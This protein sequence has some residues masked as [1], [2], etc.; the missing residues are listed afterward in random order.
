MNAFVHRLGAMAM[1]VLAATAITSPARAQDTQRLVEEVVAHVNADI[2]TRSQYYEA[3]ADAERD[4]KENFKEPEATQKFLEFRPKILD[5]MI[6]NMLLVQKGQDLQIDVEAQINAQLKRQADEQRKSITEFEEMMRSAGIDPNE[7]RARLRE[8]MMRDAVLQQEVYGGIWRNLTEKQK[9][10]FY[11]AHKDKFLEPG[12]LKISEL[13]LSVEGRSFTEIEAKA[14]EIIAAAR[15]GQK[16]ADLVKKFGDPGRPSFA[17]N[18]SIGSFKSAEELAP[19]FAKAI[20]SLKTGDVTEPMRLGTDGVIILRLDERR[21][22]A[23][24]KFEDVQNEVS[25]AMVFEQSREAETKYLKKLR[26]E[27]YIK[28]SDGYV[29][30]TAQAAAS[31][32]QA[33]STN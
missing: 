11:D 4:F 22:A 13:F 15:G 10:D 23:P 9:R 6:D 25:Y 12:E 21:E 14:K 31:G 19:Q 29:S 17:N 30:E 2:I 26:D 32:S 16:F 7:V 5:M 18:G 8:R 27:A 24:K 28:V 1:T 20:G 3:I 33:K